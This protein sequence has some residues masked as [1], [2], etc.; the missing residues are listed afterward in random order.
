MQPPPFQRFLDTYKDDVY[1]FVRAAVGPNGADDCWQETWLA[2]LRAYP[3]LQNGANLKAWVL[4]IAHRKSIDYHRKAA[5]D[6]IPME[7]VRDEPFGDPE[8]DAG[9]WKSVRLLPPKQRTAVIYRYVND[10]AYRDIGA[11]MN[12]TAEAARQN[13]HEGLKKLRE[14]LRS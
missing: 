4:T 5:R 8:P 3:R 6:A 7:T 12:T 10:L 13:A 2:A 14:E 11:A 1:R 9:L